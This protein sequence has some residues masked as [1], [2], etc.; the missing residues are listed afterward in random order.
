MEEN[1][2]SNNLVIIRRDVTD[3]VLFELIDFVTLIRLRYF[4]FTRINEGFTEK[5]TEPNKNKIITNK[6]IGRT[7]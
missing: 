7:C 4:V 6:Y 2:L 3:N 1:R 5:N